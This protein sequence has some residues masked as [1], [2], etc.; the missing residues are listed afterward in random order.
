MKLSHLSPSIAEEKNVESF[1]LLRKKKKENKA[2][3]LL[4][5]CLPR[6]KAVLK[7]QRRSK[8]RTGR[9][10]REGKQKRKHTDSAHIIGSI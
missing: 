9:W 6:E 5:F 1:K 8:K 10:G 4:V 7:P 3:T 2:S